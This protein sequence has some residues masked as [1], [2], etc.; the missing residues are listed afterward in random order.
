MYCTIIQKK[1]IWLPQF[2]IE[3]HFPVEKS[4]IPKNQD[5]LVEF[6]NSLTLVP[7]SPGT[8]PSPVTYTFILLSK[9]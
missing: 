7:S 6:D 2:A 5:P 8:V 9:L 1:K 3:E 4:R